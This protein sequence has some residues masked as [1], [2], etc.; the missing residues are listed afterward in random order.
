MKYYFTKEE[1]NIIKDK[2]N[3][4]KDIFICGISPKNGH[5]KSFCVL[6]NGHPIVHSELERFDRIKCSW[7]DHI[8]LL[9][10]TCKEINSLDYFAC[11]V[12]SRNNFNGDSSYEKLCQ[13]NKNAEDLIL[14]SHHCAH[15]AHAFYSSNFDDALIITLDGM[16]EKNYD[17]EEYYTIYYGNNLDLELIHESPSKGN[18][19]PKIDK[20]IGIL[21]FGIIYRFIT[22]KMKY[23]LGQEGSLMA[24]VAY[25]KP[26]YIDIMNKI[27]GS[28]NKQVYGFG[29]NLS[30]EELLFIEKI[31]YYSVEKDAFSEEMLEKD[32]FLYDVAAS[33]QKIFEI[34]LKNIINKGI[35]LSKEKNIDVKNICFC[36]GSA[37]NCLSMNKVL[38]WFPNINIYIPP[39]P[40]DAGL[41]LGSAQYLW[42]NIFNQPRIQWSGFFSPYLGYTYDTE[43]INKSIDKFKEYITIEKL[44]NEYKTLTKLL[45]EQKLIALF[46]GGSESG[47]RA[48]G[49][50]SIV[51][52]PR[53]PNMK[54]HI[55]ERVKHRKWFRPFAPSML[56]EEVKNWFTKDVDSPYMCIALRFKEGKQDLVPAVN[57]KDNTARLQTVSKESNEWYYNLINTWFKKTNVP[58]LLNTSFNDTEPICETP[59]H[60]LNCYLKTDIDYLYFYDA[61]L[62]IKRNNIKYI[63]EKL[64]SVQEKQ[65]NNSKEPSWAW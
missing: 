39:V 49:N 4:N 47:R 5:D 63:P 28:V 46:G 8:K 64:N 11:N 16:G 34:S 22:S 3:K 26:I 18:T 37:L 54:N 50:R 2:F 14:V 52:D 29:N 61:K 55:N 58:I 9:N 38:D 12:Q 43:C 31:K 15:A 35:E 48:L 21:S 36:G 17:E 59:D 13:I 62:L 1:I 41:S 44:D 32:T 53:N 27:V 60:A 30:Q 57:H 33:L 19:L 10:E 6:K 23:S 7:Y 65:W 51:G 20:D 40:Y 42:H 24:M 25:G 56:R 45:E